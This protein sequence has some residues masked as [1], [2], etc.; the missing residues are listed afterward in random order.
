MIG[1]RGTVVLLL[2]GATSL[3]DGQTKPDKTKVIPIDTSVCTIL[4]EPS[5]FN[6]KLVKVRGYVRTSF[7]YSVLLNEHCPNDEIW[8]AVTDGSVPPELQMTVKGTGSPCGKNSKGHPIHA[9]PVHLV[10]DEYVC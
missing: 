10:E 8:F 7:E 2:V 5:A 4:A 1:L 9:T 3:V 6:N